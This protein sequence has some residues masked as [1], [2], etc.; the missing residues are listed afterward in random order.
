MGSRLS[1]DQICFVLLHWEYLSVIER[2]R[3]TEKKGY[4]SSQ[5]QLEDHLNT[6]STSST[7]HHRTCTRML[8][9]HVYNDP[10]STSA[11]VCSV[12]PPW[13]DSHTRNQPSIYNS[14]RARPGTPIPTIVS[15]RIVSYYIARISLH[16]SRTTTDSSRP[17]VLRAARNR[18]QFPTVESPTATCS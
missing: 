4:L 10:S 8:K 7:Y 9:K 2:E 6:H 11:P 16:K 14:R 13:I 12:Q 5:P 15:Y 18:H 3:E 1:L 17:R